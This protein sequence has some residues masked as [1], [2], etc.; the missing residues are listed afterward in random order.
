MMKS[1]IFEIGKRY[2]YSK[3]EFTMHITI[4]RAFNESDIDW[5]NK[6]SSHFKEC[7]YELGEW[8]NLALVKSTIR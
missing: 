8:L 6:Q 2:V 7:C 1:K 4:G 5:I 3:R